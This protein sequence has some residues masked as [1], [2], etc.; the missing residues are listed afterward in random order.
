MRG[1]N[2]RQSLPCI[3]V[4]LIVSYAG[5]DPG[6]LDKIA[7]SFMSEFLA[8]GTTVRTTVFLLS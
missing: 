4:R 2:T 3:K 6:V 1:P 7:K 5:V 8:I